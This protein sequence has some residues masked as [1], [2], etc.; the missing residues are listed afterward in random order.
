M[1]GGESETSGASLT[2]DKSVFEALAAFRYVL[3]RFLR[4]S[5]ENARAAGLTPQ[6]YQVLLAIKGQPG[7]EWATVG[8]LAKAL[9]V[10]HHAA[11]GLVDRCASAGLARRAPDPDDRRHVR[12]SLTAR[13]DA[14]LSA[15]VDRNRRELA[16][17]GRAFGASARDWSVHATEAEVFAEVLRRACD[18]SGE[19]APDTIPPGGAGGGEG[20]KGRSPAGHG[21]V[22]PADLRTAC[23]LLIPTAALL[24]GA[25]TSV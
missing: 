9:Q 1:T 5:E 22:T 2:L 20:Q 21:R 17:L 25:L 3:R 12:V 24:G 23:V 15:L 14:V 6:Q 16:T 18:T 11:V 19:E 7:R 8:E 13:G 10:T 4:F